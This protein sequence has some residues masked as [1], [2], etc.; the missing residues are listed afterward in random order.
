M[1]DMGM[2]NENSLEQAEVNPGFLQRTGNVPIAQATVDHE[3]GAVVPD[4]GSISRAGAGENADGEVD[5]KQIAIR[6]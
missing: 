1:I 4:K 5:V 3:C 6:S 2:G